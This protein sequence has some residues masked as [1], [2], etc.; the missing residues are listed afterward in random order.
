MIVQFMIVHDCSLR[1][2]RV[3]SL[4]SQGTDRIRLSK[5]E[6]TKKE[7]AEFQVHPP[8]YVGFVLV[9]KF[10]THLT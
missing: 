2:L 4:K 10:T 8:L 1:S 3:Q 5:T 7:T 9:L 6:V